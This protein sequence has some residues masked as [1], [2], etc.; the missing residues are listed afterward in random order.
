MLNTQTPKILESQTL[1]GLLDNMV[2]AVV[3]ID[4]NGNTEYL[5][6]SASRLADILPDRACGQSLKSLFTLL[7]IDTLT[8]IEDPLVWLRIHLISKSASQFVQLQRHD[9]NKIT[10]DIAISPLLL[11]NNT[12]AGM[13]LVIRNVSNYE[14]NLDRLIEAAQYDE[15]T[16]LLRRSVL[17]HRLEHV[18]QPKTSPDQHALLFMDLDHFKEINDT[19]GHLAGDQALSEIS[20]L[21]RAQARERDTLARIG[22][23]E[24]ALL[25][26]HCSLASAI[27]RAKA[28]K[29]SVKQKNL[30]INDQ[31]FFLDISIGIA[32]FHS[33]QHS[34]K[35][36]LKIADAAC[37]RAKRNG[38]SI[39]KICSSIID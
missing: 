15:N 3:I 2:D 19:A 11:V 36:I 18:L 35:E 14:S 23:D 13:M 17:E 6:Q 4:A 34:S 33:G 39:D 37:Y 1:R 7:D 12:L 9:R 16:Q 28:I 21:F 10:V 8:P 27:E 5:N 25:L 38:A 31:N 24:F 30:T 20:G 26:E 32:A 22:G 29:N